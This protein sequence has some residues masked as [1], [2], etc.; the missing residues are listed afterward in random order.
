MESMSAYS[1]GESLGEAVDSDVSIQTADEV[2]VLPSVKKLASKFNTA[3]PER[4]NYSDRLGKDV[5]TFQRFYYS[6]C[7][8]MKHKVIKSFNSKSDFTFC[9]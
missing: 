1:D 6:P 5:S 9:K 8:V 3:S 7:I 4:I 2:P